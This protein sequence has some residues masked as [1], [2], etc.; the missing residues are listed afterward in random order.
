MRKSKKALVLL[1]VLSLL[2]S[3]LTIFTS[4]CRASEIVEPGGLKAEFFDGMDLTNPCDTR[5]TDGLT[6]ASGV[7]CDNSIAGKLTDEYRYS[8]RWTGYIKSDYTDT[9]KLYFTSGDGIRVW[10]NNQLQLDKWFDQCPTEYSL[11][12]AM[13]AGQKYP[14][15]IEYYSNGNDASAIEM[16]WSSVYQTGNAKVFIPTNNLY[17]VVQTGDVTKPSTP[18]NLLQY[19]KTQTSIDLSWSA[20]YDNVGISKYEIYRGIKYSSYN[21]KMEVISYCSDLRKIGETLTTN[22]SDSNLEPNMKL[23][24]NKY[25]TKYIYRVR[26]FDLNGNYSDISNELEANTVY[27]DEIVPQGSGLKATYY[28]DKNFTNAVLK[29]TDAQIN[30]NWGTSRPHSSMGDEFSAR[31]YGYI[32]PKYNEQYRFE[33]PG[34]LVEDFRESVCYRMDEGSGNKL[35]N[36]SDMTKSLSIEGD[37]SSSSW[38]DGIS[39]KG[40]NFNGVN[41]SIALDNNSMDDFTVSFWIK[42]S[43]VGLQDQWYN[44]IGLV[45]ADIGGLANDFGI[46]LAGK[47][48]GVGIG[49]PDSTMYSQTDISDSNW[50]HCTVSRDKTNGKVKIYI[51]GRLENDWSVT[52]KETLAGSMTIGRI[53]SGNNYFNGSMDNLMIHNRVLSDNEV[54]I[55]AEKY[56][57]KM[58]NSNWNY[59]G[60]TSGESINW[61]QSNGEC[62]IDSGDGYKLIHNSFNEKNIVYQSD[63][64]IENSSSYSDGGLLFRVSNAGYGADN[65]LGYYAALDAFNHRIVLSKF[66]LINGNYTYTTIDSVNYDVKPNIPYHMKVVADSSNIKVFVDEASAPSKDTNPKI[67]ISDSSHTKGSVGMRVYRTKTH[68]DNL[69]VKPLANKIKVWIDGINIINYSDFDKEIE[70]GTFTMMPGKKYHIRID[71]VNQASNASLMLYWSSKST[72][73]E[74]IPQNRLYISNSTVTP[75]KPTGLKANKITNTS[76]SLEWDVPLDMNNIQGYEIFRNGIP[77]G[78]VK[79]NKYTDTGLMQDTT[80][81]Y[82]VYAFSPAILYSPASDEAIVKTMKNKAPFETNVIPVIVLKFIP[83]QNK[84]GKVDEVCANFKNMNVNDLRTRINN[85]N[86]SFKYAVEKGSIYKG[87]EN[88]SAKPYINYR[89]IMEVEIDTPI[90]TY[91]QNGLVYDDYE[92]VLTNKLADFKDFTFDASAIKDNLTKDQLK[93]YSLVDIMKDKLKDGLKAR[94]IWSWLYDR[95]HI[96]GSE[97]IMSGPYGNISNSGNNILPSVGYTYTFFDF[98]YEDHAGADGAMEHYTHQIEALLKYIDGE[99]NTDSK[100]TDHDSSLFWGRF[101]GYS[102]ANTMNPAPARNGWTHEP[103]NARWNYDYNG[104]NLNY[105]LSDIENWNPDGLGSLKNINATTWLDYNKDVVNYIGILKNQSRMSWLTYWMQNVPSYDNGLVYNGRSLTNWWDFVVNFDEAMANKK[106]LVEN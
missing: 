45:D 30:F 39:K 53:N 104:D 55:L 84:D 41:N 21:V 93:N 95:E 92:K 36:S 8:A 2:V 65:L 79:G 38:V 17:H 58:Y 68:F 70:S 66:V 77:I 81:T 42:T 35:Y 90:P 16:K 6:Y 64:T 86:S 10:I 7:L 63:I 12:Y 78:Q 80:Y 99:K 62:I 40:F 14:V 37:I 72:Q 3:N 29:K 103:P 88:P 44:G 26:A 11:T 97:S 50:H 48:L 100:Y 96:V 57:G 34:S 105:T 46:V 94:Q 82:K 85:M 43:Q 102:N 106:R 20:A 52:N 24:L 5:Y 75:L 51:D 71:Y 25:G 74:I 15:K 1:I 91:S 98:V 9:Y 31:W 47:K 33:V 13:A 56:D 87:Y 32:Q 69:S 59:Y 4:K 18:T 19:S 89:V 23:E 61:H 22:F 28:S 76:V 83:D 101:V 67:N 49:N 60:M 73:K 27:S 54:K